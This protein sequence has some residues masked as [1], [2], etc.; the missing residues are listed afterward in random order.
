MPFG[1]ESYVDVLTEL[2]ESEL[3]LSPMPFGCESYV[4]ARS[5]RHC[6]PPRVTSPM[7]FGCESYVDELVRIQSLS[8]AAESHQCLSA[9]SPMWTAGVLAH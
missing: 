9:V 2:G 5:S 3:T 6:A 4:D 8:K 7:P 1:C